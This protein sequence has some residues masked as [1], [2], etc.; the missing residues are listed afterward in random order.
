MIGPRGV[1]NRTQLYRHVLR[2][3]AQAVSSIFSLFIPFFNIEYP[4]FIKSKTPL[5]KR[6]KTIASS[7]RAIIAKPRQDDKERQLFNHDMQN[8][9][10]FMRSQ[11]QHKVCFPSSALRIHLT[12]TCVEID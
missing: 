12:Y 2:E 7:L 9:I 8:V 1:M 11:R 3:I 4:F 6:D 10:T 5:A